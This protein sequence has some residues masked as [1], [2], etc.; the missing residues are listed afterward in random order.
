MKKKITLKRHDVLELLERRE[1]KKIDLWIVENDPA[2][3]VELKKSIKKIQFLKAFIKD[4]KNN[5]EII[6]FILKI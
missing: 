5:D 1:K 2:E 6:N 3:K 4:A